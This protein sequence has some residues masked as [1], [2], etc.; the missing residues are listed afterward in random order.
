MLVLQHIYYVLILSCK[1]FLASPFL[2][3]TISHIIVTQ[4]HTETDRHTLSRHT[5]KQTQ[6]HR[7]R[8]THAMRETDT[9]TQRQRQTCIHRERHTC[10]ERATHTHTHTV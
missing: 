2:Q 8:D 7:G 3:A 10:I 6:T 9:N 4:M 1:P 5:H